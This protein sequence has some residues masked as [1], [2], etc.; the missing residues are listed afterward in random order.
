MLFIPD[1]VHLS[2]AAAK[3]LKTF[4][5]RIVPVGGP[6]LLTKD[7]YDQ[8]LSDVPAMARAIPFV[9]GK[10]TWQ[11]LWNSLPPELP[12]PAIELT[13][14]NGHPQNAVQWQIGA[15]AGNTLVINR[16]TVR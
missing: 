11:Q 9:T 5:G 2:A 4:K 14:P 13:D 6:A 15:F 8:P 16:T 1:N 12:K 7:E 10:T 3:M